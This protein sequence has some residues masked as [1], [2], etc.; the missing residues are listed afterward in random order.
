MQ[1]NPTEISELI[2]KRIA[3]FE[4]VAEARTE[5]TIVSVTDG[6]VRI[7]GLA[8]VMSGE[9]IEFPGDTFGMALN[10]ERDSVGAVVLGDYKHIK[11]GDTVKCTGRILEVPIGPALLG[12]V[13]D[14]LGRPLDGKGPIE[15]EG[16]G[17]IEKLAPG[18]IERKSVDQPVQIGLK[19][20]DAMVPIGRGQRELIIGDRQT[21][22]TAIAIDAIINQKGTGVKCIYVAI[23]QKTSSVANLV[24]KLEEHDA[25]EH[26]IVVAAN[27]SDS[28]AMQFIAPYAGCTMGE[29][30]RDR[31]EDAL[32]IYD[33]LT[34]QAWAYREVSLLLRRPPGR[35]AYPGDVFF[36]HSRLLER[37]ARVNA[38]YVEKFTDGKVKGKTGSLTA[39]PIIET[40]AGDVSAFVPTNVISITDGQIFLETD[41]FNAGI[42]PAI[43]AGLSVSRVGG[44]AQT[45]I[46]KK[47]GGGVRLAL[48]QYRELAAFS[49]FA[50]DLDEATRKQL[51][52][53]ERVME[54]MKQGQYSPMSIAEMAFS[55]F[56]ANEGFLDDVEVNKV[57]DFEAAMLSYLQSE[58]SDLLNSINSSGDYNDE[59]AADMRAA[60]ESFK[61]TSTW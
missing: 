27:A 32:I 17:P 37:A 14:S 18:V 39:L 60:L 51:E 56:A 1:L 23:G 31:G 43:N 19:S 35:E 34:K 24:R 44:S 40:Q 26:T 30:F 13:V 7:H 61:S 12:R 6:I 42:R 3:D 16:Y 5:G 48:A 50:S 2:K 29:Y 54:L 41:L 8:D 58:K 21:G 22:K 9:M 28:A 10:L 25:M 45:T 4:S 49:Q 55:L 57:V 15:N 20:I 52:R 53:G 59:I 46:I 11:E 47:L 36:L 38:E 33:D